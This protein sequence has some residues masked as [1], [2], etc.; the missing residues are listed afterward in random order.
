M[1]HILLC[2][3]FGS[4]L[5][6]LW[7]HFHVFHDLGS[8]PGKPAGPHAAQPGQ[9]N[10]ELASPTRGTRL[11]WPSSRTKAQSTNQIYKCTKKHKKELI[12]IYDN[13]HQIEL[14]MVVSRLLCGPKTNTKEWQYTLLRT[15]PGCLNWILKKGNY[16]FKFIFVRISVP[17]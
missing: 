8:Q 10:M 16:I 5:N 14:D 4:N 3:L 2:A 6:R 11:S 15:R 13:R 17:E 9:R 7:Q 1:L 12:N